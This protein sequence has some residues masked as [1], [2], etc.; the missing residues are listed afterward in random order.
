[1]NLRETIIKFVKTA[2]PT[3]FEL[4]C[5]LQDAGFIVEGEVEVKL[6]DNLLIAFGLSKEVADAL[7]ELKQAKI[8]RLESITLLDFITTSP[9]MPMLPVVTSDKQLHNLKEPHWIP[10][11]LFLDP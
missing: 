6:R 5:H 1:M 7:C 4:T 10:V 3:V 8:I 11:R 9:V 2:T